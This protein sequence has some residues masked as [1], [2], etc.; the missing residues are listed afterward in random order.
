[1]GFL[2]DQGPGQM[3]G[4]CQYGL[5]KFGKL[6]HG[7]CM[8]RWPILEGVVFM[9]DHGS[10]EAILRGIEAETRGIPTRHMSA[11]GY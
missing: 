6:V 10:M 8:V 2:P 5:A 11:A 3:Q 7:K 9:V 1:M 4:F